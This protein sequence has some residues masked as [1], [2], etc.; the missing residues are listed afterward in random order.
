MALI[1]YQVAEGLEF[2]PSA[3]APRLVITEA[4]KELGDIPGWRAFID[5]NYVSPNNLEVRNR[6]M[7][8]NKAPVMFGYPVETATF[9]N[10]APA[11]NS[12]TSV[13]GSTDNR[14]SGLYSSWGINPTA[15]SVFFAIQFNRANT[16]FS[17]TE[18]MRG[19]TIAE[20][21]LSLRITARASGQLTVYGGLTA[22]LRLD[23]E[24][25]WSNE[26]VITGAV[27][28]SVEDGIRIFKNKVMTASAPND[29]RPLTGNLAPGQ[30]YMLRDPYNSGDPGAPESYHKY[31]EFYMFDTDMGSEANSVYRDRIFSRLMRVHGVPE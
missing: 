31:G 5:P 20:G 27:T 11:L 12:L 3:V 6:A 8:A 23:D 17:G 30:M 21:V 19:V 13:I 9:P 10:G 24:N 18:L 7:P 2:P 26:E 14:F 15:W 1:N 16:I 29:K 28:F 4:G 22:D 25:Y